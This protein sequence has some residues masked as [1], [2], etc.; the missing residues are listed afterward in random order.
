MPFRAS[1]PFLRSTMIHSIAV[2]LN[3]MD[4][5]LCEIFS[6]VWHI[7]PIHSSIRN[8]VDSSTMPDLYVQV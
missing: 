6:I 8:M 7:L 5:W 1:D 2:L 4:D 3:C